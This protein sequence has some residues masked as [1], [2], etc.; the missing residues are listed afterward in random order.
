LSTHRELVYRGKCD[1]EHNQN[2]SDGLDVRGDDLPDASV[3]AGRAPHEAGARVEEGDAETVD[4]R[5]A[6]VREAGSGQRP[7]DPR[8]ELTQVVRGGR[9]SR[10]SIAT[11]CSTGLKTSVAA[12]ATRWVGLSSVTRSGK[13][14][15]SSR[16]SRM[17]RSY[18][19]SAISGRAS[20]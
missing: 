12:P 18:S 19:A 6:H 9:V 2:G 13:R 8:L 15:S 7:T 1:A 10:E 14:A 11:W 4:L 5:L 20:T 3:A 16:S 17:S